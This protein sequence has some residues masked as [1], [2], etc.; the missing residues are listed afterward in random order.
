[1]TSLALV[2]HLL[3]PM[4]LELP[5]L[6][7]LF[8]GSRNFSGCDCDFQTLSLS[9]YECKRCQQRMVSDPVCSELSLI[10]LEEML[11]GLT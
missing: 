4:P 3:H 7:L 9:W 5:G 11:N 2:A 10:V 6:M 1:M 8:S